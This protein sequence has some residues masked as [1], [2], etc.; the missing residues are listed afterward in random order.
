M[1]IRDRVEK[2]R[3]HT[4]SGLEV[5]FIE[6]LGDNKW[7]VLFPASR[8]KDTQVV[9]L[10]GQI[11]FKLIKR[12]IPQHILLSKPIDK[13]YFK[14]F[15]QMALPPYIQKMRGLRTNNESDE[16]TYQTDWAQNTGS[17]AAPTASLHFNNQDLLE[18]K[19]KGV[20]ICKLT[21]HV[22]L[23]TFLP[24]REE[25]ILKHQMHSEEVYIP[26]ET[27]EKLKIAKANNKNIGTLGTTATRAIESIDKNYFQT[28]IDKGLK[29]STDLFL[30]PGKS[31]NYVNRLMTNF[32][33][34]KS[35]LIALVAAFA[36]LEPVKASYNWA[37]DC[38][39]YTS[40][41]PRDQRGSRMPSSA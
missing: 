11:N 1:C 27:I 22:G 23:G 38:L 16:H 24:I 36:G 15:G 34:P 41:S 4:E 21:L 31:F 37:I 33:Q 30:Y 8:I 29:G 3:V 14:E 25:N 19:E 40:P 12:G 35:T 18:L 39:L 7:Q 2:R 13:D 17:C 6:D 28:T 10:P 26:P 20:K 32:H 9:E 5:L